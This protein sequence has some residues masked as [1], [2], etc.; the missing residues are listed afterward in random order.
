MFRSGDNS[1]VYRQ[2][3]FAFLEILWH[4]YEGLGLNY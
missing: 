3:L 2:I 4:L 1:S